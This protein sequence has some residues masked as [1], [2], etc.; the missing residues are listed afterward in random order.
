[1][2]TI[3]YC[4]YVPYKF[5]DNLDLTIKIGDERLG[6]RTHQVLHNTISIAHASKERLRTTRLTGC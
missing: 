2:A 5:Q 4:I 1:M 3:S 6:E